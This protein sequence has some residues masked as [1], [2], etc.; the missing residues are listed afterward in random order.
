MKEIYL[1]GGCFWGLQKYF[2]VVTGV[3]ST[4]AG[5][6]NGKTQNPTYREVCS[7]SGHA[8]AVR[9]QYDESKISLVF[10]LELFYEAIDPLAI[11]RQGGDIGIQY[12]SG[13]YYIDS[14]DQPVI[15][16]SL[17]ELQKKYRE[18]IAIE[19][20]PLW[21]YTAAEEQHQAYLD[22]N[23]GGYCH[24]GQDKIQKAKGAQPS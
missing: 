9:V 12:R 2:D 18:P 6:A 14:N 4:E 23:P 10:L 16:A 7:G 13:I 5:Y 11:N 19:V 21:H 8:E 22:K 17:H 24:I 3:V 20:A 1:A 15:K